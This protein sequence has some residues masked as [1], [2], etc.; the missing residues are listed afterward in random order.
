MIVDAAKSPWKDADIVGKILD[1]E[2]ALAH[3]WIKEVF[4]ITD[5]MVVED[6]ALKAYLNGMNS[7]DDR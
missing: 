7:S 6:E 3:D 5:H 1:R 4:H 2:E